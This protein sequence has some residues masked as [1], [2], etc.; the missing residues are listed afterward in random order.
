MLVTSRSTPRHVW[1]FL[2]RQWRLTRREA[3]KAFVDTAVYGAG[4]MRMEFKD[5]VLGC[6]HVPFKDIVP[7]WVDPISSS[8]APLPR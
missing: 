8:A 3:D 2:H 1:K 6:H 5:G 4:F 7:P